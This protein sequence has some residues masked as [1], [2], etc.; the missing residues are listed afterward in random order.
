M[1]DLFSLIFAADAK[2]IFRYDFVAP[3]KFP[4]FWQ[5]YTHMRDTK[6]LQTWPL[7][8]HRAIEHEPHASQETIDYCP[9]NKQQQLLTIA[10]FFHSG[11]CTVQQT[12][13]IVKFFKE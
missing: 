4:I 9:W 13:V 11:N 5:L 3:L 10:P 8:F 7:L 6:V 12:F 1:L 2:I